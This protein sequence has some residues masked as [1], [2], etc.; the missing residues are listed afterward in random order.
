[1]TL[2]LI[3][4][5]ASPEAAFPLGLGY[6]AAAARSA[7][8]AVRGLDLARDGVRGLERAAA[9]PAVRWI[10][11]SA[12]TRT[13]PRIVRLTEILKTARPDVSFLLGGPHVTCLPEASLRESLADVAVIG[14]GER[15]LATLLHLAGGRSLDGVPGIA[16]REGRRIRLTARAEPIPSIDALAFPDRD[17]LP[18]RRYG[19]GMWARAYPYASLITSRGCTAACTYCPSRRLWDGCWRPRSPDNVLEEMEMVRRRYH[20]RHFILED[21]QFLGAPTRVEELCGRLAS[22]N[23]PFTWELP[24]GVP[25]DQLTVGQIPL[26]ARGGCVSLTLSLETR[27]VDPRITGRPAF[28]PEGIR[29]RIEACHRHGIFVGGYFLSGFPGETRRQMEGTLEDALRLPLDS[30]HFS[31]LE[32]LPGTLFYDDR[33]AFERDR[34]PAERLHDFQGRAYRR[35]YRRP[36]IL[37]GLARTLL[38]NPAL[39]QPL[40]R[41]ALATLRGT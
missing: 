16:F 21:D 25:P 3:H 34:L 22:L 13:W 9:D 14:E 24:N 2:L 1:M 39:L 15:T 8:I 7:G 27:H 10:G 36:G 12:F 31:L 19:R 6:L 32:P 26:L 4:V 41:K 29:E 40:A 18:V 33:E 28:R 37:A 17:F 38:R 20:I 35:F 11:F 5:P 23:R 30:A